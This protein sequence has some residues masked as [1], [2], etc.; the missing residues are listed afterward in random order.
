MELYCADN[1]FTFG[2][3]GAETPLH[4]KFGVGL[5]V[6]D[7]VLLRDKTTMWSKLRFVGYDGDHDKNYIMGAYIDADRYDVELAV[8]HKRLSE[9]FGIGN[10]RYIKV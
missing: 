4:D 1:G 6:G 5:C 2:V 8:S 7:V 3:V 10:V 9:G